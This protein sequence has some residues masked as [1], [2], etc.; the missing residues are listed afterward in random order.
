[1]T[2]LPHHSRPVPGKLLV[3]STYLSNPDVNPTHFIARIFRYL[4]LAF[5]AP[6]LKFPS[7]KHPK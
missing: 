2:G 1:M 4:G 6:K 7:C 5:V 3:A